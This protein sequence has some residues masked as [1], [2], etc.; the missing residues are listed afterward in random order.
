MNYPVRFEPPR[1]KGVLLHSLF[2]VLLASV[3]LALL[4]YANSQPPGVGGILLYVAA[5]GFSLPAP[6]FFYRLYGLLKS[7]YW[8]AKG[9]IRLRW[10]LRQVDIPHN[11][12]VDVARA[13]E[14]EKGLS[15]PDWVWPG[16]IVGEV[17]DAELGAV[18]FLAS[19]R[20][21]LVLLGTKDRVYAISPEDPLRYIS[22]RK[23]VA[24]SGGLT[25]IL[26]QSVSPSFVLFEVWAEPRAR[27]LL[28][29][30]AIASLGL[31]LL[32][33]LIAPTLESVSLGYGVDGIPSPPVA[34]V[35]LF[36]L[37]ALNLLFFVGSFFLG[38]L[39]F[40]E[41]RGPEISTLLWG[42]SFVTSSLFLVAILFIL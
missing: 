37:P 34:G 3:S 19:A 41:K 29:L 25:S 24:E 6:F 11:E 36:L 35:Q 30:G 28:I 38:L 4:F 10:G 5:L 13:E 7:G 31:L 22:T 15:F 14:L 26:F 1:R 20:E 9:G 42:A 18:E 33:G 16:A 32:V 23:K 12:I 2:L 27:R 17:Q 40:Q 39:F 8:I 21:N